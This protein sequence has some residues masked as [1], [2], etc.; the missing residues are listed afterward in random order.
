MEKIVVGFLL[1]IWMVFTLIITF[2]IVGVMI[3]F[4]LNENNEPSTWMKIGLSLK[5]NFTTKHEN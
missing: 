4:P 3:L 5:E 2:S 1:F